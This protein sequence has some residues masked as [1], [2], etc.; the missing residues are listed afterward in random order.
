MYCILF[1][2]AKTKG[3]ANFEYGPTDLFGAMSSAIGI[4]WDQSR[5]KLTKRQSTTS[6]TDSESWT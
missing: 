4:P 3:G 5:T 1:D 2:R 6:S